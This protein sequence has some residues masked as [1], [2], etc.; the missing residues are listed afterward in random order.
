MSKNLKAVDKPAEDIEV[1]AA[2]AR[3]KRQEDCGQEINMI[4]EKYKCNLAVFLK[5]G[6]DA[7]PV[8]R[9]IAVPIMTT[10]VSR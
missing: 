2:Q 7:V 4:L 9:V 5:F 3:Q 10:C 6:E 8:E 1:L